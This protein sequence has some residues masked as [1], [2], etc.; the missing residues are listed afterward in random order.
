MLYAN[1]FGHKS[2]RSN[3]QLQMRTALGARHLP[4][5]LNNIFQFVQTIDFGQ[6]DSFVHKDKFTPFFHT[7]T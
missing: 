2:I 5:Q 6:V 4:E 7:F 3:H 1:D